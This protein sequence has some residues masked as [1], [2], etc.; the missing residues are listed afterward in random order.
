MAFSASWENPVLSTYKRFEII[1]LTCTGKSSRTNSF[2]L[3]F[4]GQG[5]CS[6]DSSMTPMSPPTQIYGKYSVNSSEVILCSVE[7]NAH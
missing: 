5:F 2:G 1:N 4:D 6:V 7:R 3:R